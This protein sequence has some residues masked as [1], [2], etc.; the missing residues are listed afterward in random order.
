M[1]KENGNYLAV[2][3]PEGAYG[4]FSWTI[5]ETVE[6][7]LNSWPETIN[8]GCKGEILGLLSDLINTVLI[9]TEQFEVSLY[10]NDMDIPKSERNQ[11]LIIKKGNQWKQRNT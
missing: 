5:F 1:I 10:T 6:F 2:K 9:T 3:V 8:P 7:G 11:W 4:P